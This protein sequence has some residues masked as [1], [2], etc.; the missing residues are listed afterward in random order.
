MDGRSGGVP[1]P[2]NAPLVAS[3][4]G[5][6]GYG[7]KPG[8]VAREIPYVDP[9][10]HTQSLTWEAHE[11]TDL[12]GARAVVAIAASYFQVPYRPVRPDDWRLFWDDAIRQANVIS[13]NQF[14]DVYLAAGIHMGTRVEGT[15]DLLSALPD[16]CGIEE[17]VAVGETGVDPVQRGGEPWPLEDQERV[18]GRQME[19]A[20]DH[21][22]PVILHTPANAAGDEGGSVSSQMG[23]GTH[24]FGRGAPYTEPLFDMERAKPR[25]AEIDVRLAREAGLPEE[26]VVLDHADDSIVEYAMEETGCHLSFSLGHGIVGT[27]EIA[28][29]IREYGPDRV[30]VDTDLAN[31]IYTEGSAFLLRRLILDLLRLGIPPADVKQ[32]VHDNPNELFGLDYP[33]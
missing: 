2:T 5:E 3:T 20:A 32:V 15:D 22:L 16:Y 21:G 27:G 17:V 12:A 18:V 26:R 31:S 9:H 8:P 33:G 6:I 13:R 14:F 19:I 30:M 1:Y 4:D 24:K 7:G 28:S 25:A 11:K 29:V 23:A 10:Q